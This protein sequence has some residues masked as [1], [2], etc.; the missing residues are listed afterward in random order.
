MPRNID[1]ITDLS[2]TDQ[3]IN[4]INTGKILVEHELHAT[5]VFGLQWT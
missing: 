5:G 2:T 1:P 3:V 4:V